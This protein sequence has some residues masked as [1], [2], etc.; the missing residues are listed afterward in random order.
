M[1]MVVVIVRLVR[2]NVIGSGVGKR[3]HPNSLLIA[4]LFLCLSRTAFFVLRAQPKNEVCLERRVLDDE[5]AYGEVSRVFCTKFQGYTITRLEKSAGEE[6]QCINATG[7]SA[8]IPRRFAVSL[9]AESFLLLRR[10]APVRF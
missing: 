6:H 7:A 8:G 10:E 4:A 9:L 1:V 5:A 3:D 2:A